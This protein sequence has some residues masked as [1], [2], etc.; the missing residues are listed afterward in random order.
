MTIQELRQGL[1]EGVVHF[2]YEK[3]D[4]TIREANGTLNGFNIPEEQYPKGTAKNINPDV[5]RYYDV[6]KQEWRSFWI[7]KLV[8]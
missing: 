1:H 4:G 8:E 6:D 5:Q 2:K 3:V 7:N